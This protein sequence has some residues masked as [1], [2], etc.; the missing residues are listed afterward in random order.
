MKITIDGKSY[1]LTESIGAAAL[2]DLVALKKHSG[3][4][5][6]TIKEMFE[7]TAE[8]A[9]DPSF[10]RFDLLDDEQFLVNMIGVIWLARRK[11]GEQIGMA[12]AE[13]ISFQSVAFDFDEETAEPAPKDEDADS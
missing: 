4:S 2:G 1:E 12:E 11:A 13:E 3:V 8:L 10:D 6:K 5:V 9:S 7:H